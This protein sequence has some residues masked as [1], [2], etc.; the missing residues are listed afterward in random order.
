MPSTNNTGSKP[1]FWKR[2]QQRIVAGQNRVQRTGDGARGRGIAVTLSILISCVL[3][4]SFTMTEEYTVLLSFPTV[5]DNLPPGAALRELPPRSVQVE[6]RGE[7]FQVFRLKYDPDVVHLNAAREEI[8]VEQALPE[9]PKNVVIQSVS[10]RIITLN[11][12][13]QVV[14]KVPVQ[15]RADIEPAEAYDFVDSIRISPD[16][17]EITG[18]R[19]VVNAIEYWPTKYFEIDDV[20]DSLVTHI[21]LADT[22]EG[23]VTPRSEYVTLTTQTAKFTADERILEVIPRGVASDKEE[24]R[25]EPATIKVSYRVRFPED[26][27]ALKRV[28]QARFYAEVPQDSLRSPEN[29]MVRPRVIV[30]EEFDIRHLKI[31]PSELRVYWR[32][33]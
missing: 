21:P 4:F 6:V 33:N 23:L 24:V 15:L 27:F 7:G 2:L 29:G 11:I 10:P 5:V 9:L 20:K 13:E 26:Y 3:W 19:T 31:T 30:P 22:L 17:V 1:S 32:Q 12:G 8:N 28:S 16:S 25:L 18:A 14:R